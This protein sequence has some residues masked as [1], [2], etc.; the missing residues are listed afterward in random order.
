MDFILT[1]T[2]SD[3]IA[4]SRAAIISCTTSHTPASC[5]APVGEKGVGPKVLVWGRGGSTRHNKPWAMSSYPNPPTLG[6]WTYRN[7]CSKM[8][9]LVQKGQRVNCVRRKKKQWHS[10]VKYSH[11][12]LSTAQR[13][14]RPFT[15]IWPCATIHSKSEVNISQ[16]VFPPSNLS[17]SEFSREN[18]SI[19]KK[20]LFALQVCE[21][22]KRL[23]IRS[24][25]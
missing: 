20:Q 25:L 14:V 1:I 18:M 19:S 11:I 10:Q 4:A 9:F 5:P 24:G 13:K 8:L 12:R 15:I 21:M 2:R 3:T 22:N 16:S 7:V 17:P 23:F 6:G